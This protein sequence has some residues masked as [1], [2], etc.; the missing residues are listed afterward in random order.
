MTDED[1]LLAAI[2]AEPDEDT[3]ALVYADWLQERGHADRAEFIRTQVELART[4]HGDDRRTALEVRELQLVAQNAAEWA[5][6]R[7][8]FPEYVLSST[9]DRRERFWSVFRRGFLEAVALHELASGDLAPGG[10]IKKLF[11][12]HP[13][14]E[15]RLKSFRPGSLPALAGRRTRP[16]RG[17]RPDVLRP[18]R[19]GGSRGQA[20]GRRRGP[21]E[22]PA[23]RPPAGINLTLFP[24]ATGP[25]ARWLRLPAL[26][27][28]Q[29]LSLWPKDDER[30][31]FWAAWAA[32]ECPEL[33]ELR[34]PSGPQR[35]SPEVVRPFTNSRRASGSC[36]SACPCRLTAKCRSRGPRRLPAPG[37]GT[38]RRPPAA[39]RRLPE[40]LAL[41]ATPATG[42]L[43]TLRLWGLTATGAGVERWLESGYAVGVRDLTIDYAMLNDDDVERLA[44]CP[45]AA[46]LTRLSLCGYGEF[47]HRGVKALFTSP[48]LAGLRHLNLTGCEGVTARALGLLARRGTLRGLRT[49]CVGKVARGRS[50]RP[51]ILN[52]T[53]GG[54]FPH[55][56]TIKG[57]FWDDEDPL[58]LRELLDSPALPN[59]TVLR[60]GFTDDRLDAWRKFA[61]GSRLAWV[62]GNVSSGQTNAGY[63]AL[64]PRDMHYPEPLG[65][66]RVVTGKRFRVGNVVL[67]PSPAWGLVNLSG[68]IGASVIRMVG[69]CL[70]P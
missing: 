43:R 38:W 9:G 50:P 48:H 69:N 45:A 42:E 21:A 66:L 32:G 68:G 31:Q 27:R 12:A 7:A 33:T 3:P 60:T 64:H 24:T 52:L 65:R 59:L 40:L 14:R 15:L 44:R 58:E 6:P 22:F 39:A 4:P 13:I 47:S 70:T 53:A 46:R 56:H 23:T 37:S 11:A 1:A 55:L 63:V 41:A 28:L 17:P 18:R 19:T 30:E 35:E 16:R 2:R 5:A 57:G 49:L 51:G 34:V 61:A 36:R 67:A 54:P 10:T 20:R 25:P 8:T 29:Q 62:G 26:T